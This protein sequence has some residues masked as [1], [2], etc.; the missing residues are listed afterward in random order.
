MPMMKNKDKNFHLT[1]QILDSETVV[2]DKT[3]KRI[4]G[5]P[6]EEEAIEFIREQEK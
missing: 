2:Y 4:Q 1:Y 5:F 6:T 3:G